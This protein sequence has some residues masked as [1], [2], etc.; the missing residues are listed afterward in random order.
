M[1][2]LCLNCNL[3]CNGSIFAR[4]PVTEEEQARLPDDLGVFHRNGNLRMRLPCSRLGEDGACTCYELR[5]DVCRS[6][7]CKL[8]NRVAANEI[9]E[10][11]ALEIIAE[12]RKAQA[13]AVSLVALAMGVP[14]GH[15]QPSQI[16]RAFR[17][18]KA[19]RKDPDRKINGFAASRAFLQRERFDR[20]V[21][22]QLQSNFKGGS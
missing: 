12:I 11:Q 18:F 3:C 16:S 17:D 15:Y 10:P 1:T 19:A 13:S 2:K 8:A 9:A 4:V 22:K 6:Y 5:P 7:N 14:S 21:R 20:L